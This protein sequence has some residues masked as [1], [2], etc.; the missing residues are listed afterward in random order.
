MKEKKQQ[1]PGVLITEDCE[2]LKIIA[3]VLIASYEKNQREFPLQQWL[4]MAL[5]AYLP[6]LGQETA[7]KISSD[8]FM[9][10]E[11]IEKNRKSL[12]EVIQR[13]R[14]RESW[15]IPLLETEMS[16]YTAKDASRL[17]RNYYASL[18]ETAER[19]TNRGI[20]ITSFPMERKSIRKEIKWNLVTQKYYAM[21]LYRLA[22]QIVV[23]CASHGVGFDLAY[24]HWNEEKLEVN[25]IKQSLTQENDWNVKAILAAILKVAT[26]KDALRAFKK[27]TDTAIFTNLA[28]LTV[29]KAK[30]MEHK[31]TMTYSL[32]ESLDKIQQAATVVLA[33]LIALDAPQGISTVF[34]L[35]GLAANGL[36][37]GSLLYVSGMKLEKQAGYCSWKIEPKLP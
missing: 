16:Q 14:C 5:A 32:K 7:E 21:H 37:H 36:L 17:I 28:Y 19:L 9:E 11:A 18:S 22:N 27:G 23:A 1:R 3:K 12:D 4:P 30:A 33:R 13:G 15:F 10:L 8:I 26:E 6:K 34:G 20:P 25:F 24:K 31:E 29:E 35:N 2:E